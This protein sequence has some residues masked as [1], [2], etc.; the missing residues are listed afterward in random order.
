MLSR[1]AENL[2][3]MSRHFERADNMA[4]LVSAHQNELLDA[5]SKPS[6]EAHKWHPLLE[7][8]QMGDEK[9]SEGVISYMVSS[10]KNPDSVMSSIFHGRENARAVNGSSLRNSDT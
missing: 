4:R 3:W 10:K 6:E 2:Y 1:V 5:T 7:V 8:T 9:S